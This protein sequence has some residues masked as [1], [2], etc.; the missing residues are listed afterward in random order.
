[1][2]SGFSVEYW[3]KTRN[4]TD[5]QT[6]LGMANSPG[7]LTDVI[8]DIG[9]QNHAKRFRILCRDDHRH[10]FE[11]S[12]YPEGGNIDIYDDRWHHIVHVYDPKA[13]ALN[14]Q[15]LIYVDGARQTLLA[16]I[17]RGL[18]TFSD[19]NN[20]ITLG[21]MNSRGVEK[22]YLEGSLEEVAFYLSPLSEAQ[23]LKHYRAAGGAK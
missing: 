5:R 23:V 11:A 6:V 8:V 18:P 15:V 10:W 4:S 22:D 9:H 19:F 14:E 3:I 1:M 21:A 17:N 20:P 12:F 16:N 7:F 13:D 2:T